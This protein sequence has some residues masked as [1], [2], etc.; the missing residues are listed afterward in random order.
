M[1]GWSVL[2][3]A[4]SPGSVCE[5]VAGQSKGR[6]GGRTCF[7]EGLA[8][9][10]EGRHESSEDWQY[11][12][13]HAG[14]SL[15]L[16]WS[17]EERRVRS[18]RSS[19]LLPRQGAGGAWNWN[20]RSA[21]TGNHFAGLRSRPSLLNQLESTR[22]RSPA[23]PTQS[24]TRR[25]SLR[26]I[27][28]HLPSPA[29]PL[30]QHAHFTPADMV[31]LALGGSYQ[32]QSSAKPEHTDTEWRPRA[33]GR[34]PARA[35]SRRHR[36]PQGRLHHRSVVQPRQEPWF[37]LRSCFR[38]DT[39]SFHLARA[40]GRD[41]LYRAVQYYARFLAYYCLRKGYSKET[42]ARLQALK[43]TLGLSRKRECSLSLPPKRL[44]AKPPPP[45]GLSSSSRPVYEPSLTNATTV[46]R[47]G[48]PVE[49]LQAAVKGLDLTDPVLKF[50]T[51][52]RQLGYAGYLVNDTL[53]WVSQR[54]S[55]RVCVRD[56]LLTHGPAA[57]LG[58]GPTVRARH[59][60]RDPAAR[61]PPVVHR[62]RLLDRLEFVQA[63]RTPAARAGC[64]SR[65]SS[66]RRHQQQ[67][68]G[69]RRQGRLADDQDV[70]LLVS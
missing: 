65:S 7:V 25:T 57:P 47:I 5:R 34:S 1:H 18:I 69:R 42:V 13:S 56:L 8:G 46:M 3:G 51:I 38:P 48:K 37:L 11:P 32:G 22:L 49:H 60:C 23:P 61:R 68:E 59:L 4:Q 66:W 15:R 43:S 16:E 35:S 67:R 12:A 52:G 2:I 40:V 63:V 62:N 33:D 21:A 50:T 64:Q 53:V 39:N 31:S 54:P 70:S 26:P 6:T 36:G 9:C 55:Q 58:Q 17:K 30:H 10:D 24:R 41:K 14:H 29:P 28:F 20:E 27:A 19:L 45:R 44:V